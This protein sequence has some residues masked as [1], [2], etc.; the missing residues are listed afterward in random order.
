VIKP[1][2][3]FNQFLSKIPT[4][5]RVYQDFAVLPWYFAIRLLMVA[6]LGAVFALVR[7]DLSLG[8][9][10]I[11][12]F[13]ILAQA[14]DLS[15]VL[16][17]LLATALLVLSFIFER[18][19]ILYYFAYRYRGEKMGVHKL[20]QGF[21]GTLPRQIKLFLLEY[22]IFFGLLVVVVI[23]GGL[24]FLLFEFEILFFLGL[25][26]LLL[27]GFLLWART[28]LAFIF[29]LF[30]LFSDDERKPSVFA[31]LASGVPKGILFKCIRIWIFYA[32][33]GLLFA[34]IGAT[35]T[36]TV[37]WVIDLL[38][39]GEIELFFLVLLIS[40]MAAL[41][42]LVA[43]ILSVFSYGDTIQ[44]LTDKTAP[45]TTVKNNSVLFQKLRIVG[46]VLVFVVVIASMTV[47]G[48]Q[49]AKPLVELTGI[50]RQV[51]AHRGA[52]IN[53]VQNSL[54]AFK[55][56][57]GEADFVEL[58]VQITK[59]GEVI[60][61]HDTNFENLT[62]E[63]GI[64]SQRNYAE[65]ATYQVSEFKEI[66]GEQQTLSAKIPLLREVF[67]AVGNDIAFAIEIKNTAPERM[68]ELVRKT[69]QLVREFGHENKSFVISLDYDVLLEVQKTSP[70][71][72]RGIILTVSVTPPEAY[73]VDIYFLN[74]LTSSYN[75]M[76]QIH[77]LDRKAY[78]WTFEGLEQDFHREFFMGAHGFIADDPASTR[79]LIKQYLDLPPT[80]K[81][82][83]ILST[84]TE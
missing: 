77:A 36:A 32:F 39:W 48:M 42:I 66:E 9:E 78:F 30:N 80:R 37:P 60:V 64:P 11:Y 56:A 21:V 5:S 38:S 7:S 8:N 75:Q 76:R 81:I 61:F 4:I 35:I 41:S 55:A 67:E 12:D 2:Q 31:E 62:G 54:A 26:P 23:L 68:E 72:R 14:V 70:E 51:F 40:T 3:V 29:A 59:D 1:K 65:I 50:E 25:L 52:S 53:N 22:V 46:P 45:A 69:I 44:V 73:D 63:V 19:I 24:L 6:L 27:V 43:S 83:S 28:F 20:L 47:T 74:A 79:E 58:D 18:N 15:A 13:G 33:L 57:V 49:K 34:A 10:P 82:I 84:F 17:L 16:S 71:I